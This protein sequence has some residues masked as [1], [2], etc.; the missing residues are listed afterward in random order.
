MVCEDFTLLCESLVLVGEDFTFLCEDFVVVCESL[1]F[2]GELLV[3][4]AESL[5]LALES[6]VFAFKGLVLGSEGFLF[7]LEAPVFAL[8][9][10]LLVLK[11]LVLS[12]EFVVFVL[13]VPVFAFETVVLVFEVLFLVLETPVGVYEVLVLVLERIVLA[14]KAG[15]LTLK[16]PFLFLESAEVEVTTESTDF[17]FI[18]LPGR[19][20]AGVGAMNLVRQNKSKKKIVIENMYSLSGWVLRRGLQVVVVV[21]VTSMAALVVVVVASVTAAVTVRT[22]LKLI[23]ELTGRRLAS[24]GTKIFD[25]IKKH[26]IVIDIMYSLSRW[27][28]RGG[29]HVVVVVVVVTS[30]AAL[31]VVVVASMTVGSNLELIYE[32]TSRGGSTKLFDETKYGINYIKYTHSADASWGT[33]TWWWWWWC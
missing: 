28:L 25:Q 14:H 10:V 21:V 1:A 26:E 22:N 19:R 11:G 23:Y 5:V 30:V 16:K 20:L 12:L 33:S 13:E 27:V 7:A 29:L 9:T 4:L 32:L 2:D 6:A 18:V 24:V 8:Q 31:V 15:V 3:L 17:K